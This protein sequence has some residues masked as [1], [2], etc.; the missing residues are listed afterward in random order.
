MSA[1]EDMADGQEGIHDQEPAWDEVPD[2]ARA[3][4]GQ[5]IELAAR[6]AERLRGEGVRRGLIG[7]REE[8]RLWDRHLLNSVAFAD[9]L[10]TESTVLDVGSGAGLP[11][12]PLA[13]ARPDLKVTL[14]EPMARRVSWLEEVVAE[15]DLPVEVVRGR[16]EE[17]AVRD[18]LKGQ[19]IVVARA[20]APLARLV[21]WCLPLVRP[22]GLLLAQKGASAGEELERDRRAIVDA[23]G[24]DADVIE[25][26][27]GVLA[28]PTNVV[29]VRRRTNRGPASGPRRSRQGN[30]RRNDR[31]D[32]KER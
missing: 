5:R 30:K 17:P 24:V 12:I 18:R 14:L 4:F 7:P 21:E 13:I 25:C 27:S 11:G 19:Q 28:E 9:L 10:P 2:A 6:F 32:R 16:A 26:G 29:S 22:G 20:L 15:L 8:E 23:G 3:L 1:I 31:P